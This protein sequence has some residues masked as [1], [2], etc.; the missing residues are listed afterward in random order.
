MKRLWLALSLVVATL[1]V[2]T[3]GAAQAQNYPNRPVRLLIPFAAGGA[4][5]TIGRVIG[6]K[7]TEQVAQP[8]IGENRA[9]GGGKLAPDVLSKSPPDGYSMLL[10]TNGLAI[11]PSLYKTLP[12]D[13]HKDFIP[14]TQVVASQL[15]IAAHPKLAASSI[16]E[17]IALAKVKPGGL[18]YGSTGIG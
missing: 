16:A 2:A 3:F 15:V 1:A 11:S 5:D 8:V 18:N 7:R 13:V 4:V 14:V 10:T 17:L 9:G 6:Q 12:F